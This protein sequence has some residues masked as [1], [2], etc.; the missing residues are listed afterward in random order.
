MM[1]HEPDVRPISEGV[2]GTFPGWRRGGVSSV[3]R[4]LVSLAR[5]KPLGFMGAVLVL[6]FLVLAVFAPV[7][8]PYDP[9]V[10]DA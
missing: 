1:H 10:Q 8:A 5:R 9:F 7:L 3:L 6:A 4:S 2:A